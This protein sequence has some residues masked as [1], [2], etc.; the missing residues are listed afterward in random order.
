MC[1]G[2]VADLKTPEQVAEE[3]W[4]QMIGV[5]RLDIERLAAAF[6]ADRAAAR[7]EALRDAAKATCP[8]FC[9]GIRDDYQQVSV[10]D[11]RP[12]FARFWWH[13]AKEY[14]SGGQLARW[15]CPAGPVR[16]LAAEQAEEGK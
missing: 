10:Q 7:A 14:M 6:A 5:A 2:A 15:E 11:E 1:E 12:A 4:N 3:W 13:V 16:A 9:G 8:F